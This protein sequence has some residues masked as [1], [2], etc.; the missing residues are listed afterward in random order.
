MRQN[1]EKLPK[2]PRKV[3]LRPSKKE[4][5]LC[6]MEKANEKNKQKTPHLERQAPG[7]PKGGRIA[8]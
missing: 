7:A 8:G 3:V 4:D 2:S 6:R 1:Q 5:S